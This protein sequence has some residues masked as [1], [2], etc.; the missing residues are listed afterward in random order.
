M[1]GDPNRHGVSR[2]WILIAVEET[3][4]ALTDLATSGKVRSIGSSSLLAS[5]ITEA[6][7]V[8]Q[9]HALARLRTEQPSYSILARGIE[10]ETLPCAKNVEWAL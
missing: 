2:R 3:L 4:A 5:D 8:W 10:R 6:Q 1:G 7:W 9:N